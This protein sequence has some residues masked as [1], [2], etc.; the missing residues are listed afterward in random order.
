M[1]FPAG[2]ATSKQRLLVPSRPNLAPPPGFSIVVNGQEELAR[3]LVGATQVAYRSA[4]VSNCPRAPP[5]RTSSRNSQ[6]ILAESRPGRKSA[7][8]E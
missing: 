8:T 4:H 3:K 7:A 2:L 6:R 5:A 1:V